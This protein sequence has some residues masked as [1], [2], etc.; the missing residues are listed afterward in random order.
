M[1]LEELTRLLQPRMFKPFRISCTDGA[2]YDITHSHQCISSA[3]SV[4][5]GI[6]GDNLPLLVSADWTIFDLVHITRIEPL[7]TGSLGN[8][9]PS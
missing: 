7:K 8:G 2:S 5:I 1:P 4:V 6:P 9:H 3:R